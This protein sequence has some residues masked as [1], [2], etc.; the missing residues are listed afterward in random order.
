[1]IN[2]FYKYSNTIVTKFNIICRNYH[3]YKILSSNSEI[4]MK[5]ATCLNINVILKLIIILFKMYH[6]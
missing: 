3:I 6:I 1:M 5:I 4:L 2:R